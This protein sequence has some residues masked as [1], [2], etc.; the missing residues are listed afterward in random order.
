MKADPSAAGHA[1]SAE[2]PAPNG[3][4]LAIAAGGTG[5]HFF[6]ALSVALEYRKKVGPVCLLVGGQQSG[7]H[8]ELA[9]R[10]GVPAVEAPALR[11]PQTV[12]GW[13]G[14][15]V[16]MMAAVWRAWRILR[17]RS[18]GRVLG[19]GGFASVPVGLA[20]TV[21]RRPLYL[22][23]GNALVGRA[24]RLLGRRA[25][26]L[27][28]SLPLREAGGS[29]DRERIV[30]FP[31]RRPLIEAAAQSGPETVAA[32]RARLGLG[33]DLPVL[34]VF[35]G[36]QGA[37]C[38]NR[39]LAEVCELRASRSSEPAFQLLQFTG[40]DAAAE[41]LQAVCER[42]AVPAR[43]AAW[44]DGMEDAYRAAD[45]VLARAGGSTI[46]ELALFGKPAILVPLPSAMDDHQT[47]NAAVL[48]ERGAA[49]HLPQG[50]ASPQAAASLLDDWLAHPEAWRER[51][52][53]L[54]DLA[55]PEAAAEIV[56][57][58]ARQR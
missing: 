14:F 38:L 27:L 6:P 39:L 23:E 42:L 17:R 24:N 35:G 56:R 43:C 51:G 10:H 8:L 31:V 4:R 32:A 30:G 58:L 22:H 9:R 2:T 50:K 40:S 37:D 34:L 19:M 26:L 5:G 53:R 54:A 45:L 29:R 7:Q 21:S 46:G 48:A 57:L 12:L 41:Q 52:Q 33:M 11:T 20:A 25:R 36:S 44:S 3:P 13:P 16:R 15:A 18:V 49:V 1:G 28:L 47:A 55:Y